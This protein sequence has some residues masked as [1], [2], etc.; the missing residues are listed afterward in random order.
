MDH[1]SW[2]VNGSQELCL[3]VKPGSLIQ[4]P[5]VSEYNMINIDSGHDHTVSNLHVIGSW[6]LEFYR[7]ETISEKMESS[8]SSSYML[9]CR[10]DPGLDADFAH[11]VRG[12]VQERSMSKY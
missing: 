2:S 7:S 10:P 5:K 8:N 9:R 11:K 6:I 1:T 12:H 4:H 3:S